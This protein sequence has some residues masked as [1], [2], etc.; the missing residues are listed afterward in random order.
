MHISH[1]LHLIKVDLTNHLVD[2][3][4]GDGEP[5]SPIL[6][7][8]AINFERIEHFA[9]VSQ[10]LVCHIVE[11]THKFEHAV[12]LIIL[13]LEVEVHHLGDEYETIFQQAHELVLHGL[14]KLAEVALD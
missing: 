13:S 4:R 1:V 11:L 5:V 14:L 6:V 9:E 7:D 10:T 8:E 2:L 3:I 12:V